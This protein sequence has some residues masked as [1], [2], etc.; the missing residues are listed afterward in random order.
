[1]E[2]RPPVLGVWSLSH[3]ITREVLG[4][5]ITVKGQAVSI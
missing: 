5:T 3:W 2:P 4:V 1:M